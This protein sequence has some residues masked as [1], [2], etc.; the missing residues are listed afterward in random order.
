MILL[1]TA[2]LFILVIFTALAI[3]L[4]QYHQSLED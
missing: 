3:I 4:M 2:F 1:L